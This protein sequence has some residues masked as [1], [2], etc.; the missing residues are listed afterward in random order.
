MNRQTDTQT[1][2]PKPICSRNIFEV[3]GIITATT[4][5]SQFW[6]L[7]VN[8]CSLTLSL[9]TLI[10]NMSCRMT[11]ATKWHVRPVKTQISLGICPVWSVFAVRKKKAW[12]L[13]YPLSAQWKLWSD[14]ADAQADLSLRWEHSHFVGFVMWRLKYVITIAILNLQQSQFHHCLY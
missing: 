11:K 13:S 2:N 12:V 14:W 9:F 7:R 3:G 10:T 6:I 4:S 1:D 8:K 5:V